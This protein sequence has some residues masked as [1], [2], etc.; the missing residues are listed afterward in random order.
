[1]PVEYFDTEMPHVLA[2]CDLIVCRSGAATLWEGAILSKAMLLIPLVSGSRGD[3]VRNAQLF[4]SAGA[5]KM[6]TNAATLA[7]D[8]VSSLKRLGADPDQRTRIGREARHLVTD[9]SSEKIVMTICQYID[10]GGSR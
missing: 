6:F 3:Q 9:D 8:V 4:C 10:G 2:A 5:A 7:A 1:V